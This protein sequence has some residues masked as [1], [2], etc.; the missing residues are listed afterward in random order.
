MKKENYKK[1]AKRMQKIRFTYTFGRGLY[2]RGYI[3]GS[4]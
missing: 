1:Q 2:N 4:I 3:Q